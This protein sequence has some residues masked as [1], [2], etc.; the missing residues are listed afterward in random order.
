LHIELDDLE[1]ANSCLLIDKNDCLSQVDSLKLENASLLDKIKFLEAQPLMPSS[2]EE[3]T[4]IVDSLMHDIDVLKSENKDRDFVLHELEIENASLLAKING[5][6]SCSSSTNREND[7]DA[8]HIDS[9]SYSTKSLCLEIDLLHDRDNINQ[10]SSSIASLKH[11]NDSLRS[12][13]QRFLVGKKNLNDILHYTTK[14]I[15]R[16]G[17]GYDNSQGNNKD[18][19][20]L[21][22][23]GESSSSKSMG[24]CNYC[25]KLGHYSNCCPFRKAPKSN[26]IWVAK[27]IPQDPKT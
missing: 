22:F 8:L 24:T 1:Y 18:K 3:H 20:P 11:D 12:S 17:L 6:E 10:L 5:N 23:H 14:Q 27:L 25:N 16:H 15:G 26:R 9:D 21:I 2:N 13:L 7:V 4:L 19:G